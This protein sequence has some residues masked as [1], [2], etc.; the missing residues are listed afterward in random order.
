ML[1]K[2]V[3]ALKENQAQALEKFKK[4]E[5]A[6]RTATSTCPAPTPRMAFSRRIP[7]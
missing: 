3:A 5:G 1:E 6:L 4:G 2:A 7:T